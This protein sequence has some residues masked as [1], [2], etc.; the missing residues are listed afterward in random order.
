M[1]T[2]QHQVPVRGGTLAVTEW[3]GDGPVVVAVHGIT[4][5]GLAWAETAAALGG[6]ARLLAPDLRGRAGSADLPGPW[7]MANHAD[8][9]IAILDHLGVE[10]AVLAGHS[11]GGFVVATAAERT[12]ARVRRVLLVDGGLPL[13]GAVAP[14]ADADVA[15]DIEAVVGAVIGPALER[16]DLSFASVEAYLD[17]FRAHP[18]FLPPNPWPASNDDYFAHD[19]GPA[20]AD[21]QYRSRV[22][23]DATLFDGGETLRDPAVADAVHRMAVP[24]VVAWAPRGILDQTPGLYAPDVIAAVTARSPHLRTVEIPDT[25]HYSI[26]MSAHGAEAVAELLL[27]ED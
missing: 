16:L 17:Y 4:A 7:G 24:T 10:Q 5:N 6:R 8:D 12:P 3:P 22:R 13:P 23:K 18:A 14:D 21:G 15:V 19:L 9:V 20:R 25:N 1:T 27:A 2:Q 26:V 11:M